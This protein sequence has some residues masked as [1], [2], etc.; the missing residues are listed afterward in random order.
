[1]FKN[2][3]HNSPTEAEPFWGAATCVWWAIRDTLSWRAFTFA[4]MRI[5]GA[6]NPTEPVSETMKWKL[7]GRA[8][9]LWAAL[10]YASYGNQ[11]GIATTKVKE[12]FH[13][14][15][16]AKRFELGYVLASVLGVW[17]LI[18]IMKSGKL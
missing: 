2:E 11:I 4:A 17:L 18:G 13:P 3:T 8:I 6:G 10:W 5:S 15:Y 16:K 9:S 14:G 1:M 7:S 12:Y